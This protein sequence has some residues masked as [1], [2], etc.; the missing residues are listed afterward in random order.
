MT[1]DPAR[2]RFFAIG[3][4]RLSGAA[5]ALLGIAILNNR[6][7]EPAEVIGGI[8]IVVGVVDLLV[9]P[10]ILARRWRTPPSK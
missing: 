7:I 8:L 1:K 10:L 4:V 5:L 9:F 2:T 3:L 6:L